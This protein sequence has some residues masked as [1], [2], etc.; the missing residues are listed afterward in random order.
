MKNT[1]LLTT[2]LLLSMIA[3]SQ[4]LLEKSKHQHSAALALLIGGGTLVTGSLI[5]A[6]TRSNNDNTGYAK[7]DAPGIV[8]VG[9]LAAMLGSIPL[10]IASSR[11][12][13][14]ALTA[15]FKFDNY[16]PGL[17]LKFRL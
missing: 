13:K 16:V 8:L 3:S 7:Y 5:W 2:G 15:Y 10:F 14:K 12:K 6:L 1:L 17:S 4:D 9:G 11:N